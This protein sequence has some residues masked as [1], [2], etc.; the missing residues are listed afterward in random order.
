MLAITGELADL[1]E[2]TAGEAGRVLVNAGA[3]SSARAG[4]LAADRG[5][6]RLELILGRTGQ[7]IT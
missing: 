3:G 1:D 4:R 7:V 2:A 6:R 5:G